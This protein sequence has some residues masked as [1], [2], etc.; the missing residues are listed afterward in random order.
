MNSIVY[1][2][3]LD[4]MFLS[5]REHGDNTAIFYLDDDEPAMFE[6]QEDAIRC[7]CDDFYYHHGVGS[8]TDKDTAKERLQKIK[9]VKIQRIEEEIKADVYIPTNIEIHE[10]YILARGDDGLQFYLKS[11]MPDWESRQ[12]SFSRFYDDDGYEFAGGDY[13][14]IKGYNE[15]VAA[16]KPVKKPRSA[17]IAKLVEEDEGHRRRRIYVRCRI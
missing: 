8:I 3:K 7:I 16:G 9:L 1:A 15:W 12:N 5:F 17:R 4:D 6:T 14:R 2:L 10:W 13:W 11:Q